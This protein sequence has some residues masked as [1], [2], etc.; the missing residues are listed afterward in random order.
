MSEMSV[1]LN[2]IEEKVPSEGLLDDPHLEDF[3]AC[4]RSRAATVA[5]ID[6]GVDGAVAA[7]MAVLSQT[8]GRAYRWDGTE[9]T[10]A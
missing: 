4:M 7:H 6:A 2:E 3:F 1:F 9:V 8:D 10:P 5:P